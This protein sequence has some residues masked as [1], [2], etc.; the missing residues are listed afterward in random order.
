MSKIIIDVQGFK[1][2][3]NKFIPKELASYNGFQLS[4]HI[5]KAP[6]KMDLLSP[7]CQKTVLW[8]MNNHHSIS[9]KNGHTPLHKFTD[10]IADIT[11]HAETVYVKGKEKADYIRKYCC[12]PVIEIEEQPALIPSEVRCF[13]HLNNQSMCALSNVLYIYNN[14]HI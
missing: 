8:L 14:F 7:E 3:N 6:F 11:K 4:H 12:K 2:E 13:N 5:F 9:W 1:I 10:I